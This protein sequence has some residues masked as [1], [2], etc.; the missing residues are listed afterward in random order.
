MVAAA[1]VVVACAHVEIG[2]DCA[3][4]AVTAVVLVIAGIV[5]S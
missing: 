3:V 1:A 5:L 4:T 2:G